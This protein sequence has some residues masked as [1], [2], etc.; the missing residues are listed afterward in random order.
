M[1]SRA[2]LPMM[3]RIG[4]RQSTV[5]VRAWFRPGTRSLCADAPAVA[6]RVGAQSSELQPGSAPMRVFKLESL[7]TSVRKMQAVSRL[8]NVRGLPCSIAASHLQFVPHKPAGFLRALLELAMRRGRTDMKMDPSRLVIDQIWC[9]RGT[10]L[11]RADYQSKGRMGLI[12]KPR[13]HLFVRVK[14]AS[15]DEVANFKFIVR[16]GIPD[17]AAIRK[18]ME[19]Q[20]Q[21]TQ[22]SPSTS[23]RTSVPRW[24]LR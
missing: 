9:G 7:K 3:L 20:S 17:R 18:R 10:Y 8:V 1:A 14:V 21:T 13:T 5:P 16:K 19:A 2:M 22:A 4:W 11:K 23:R 24:P 12:T 15:A 6:A